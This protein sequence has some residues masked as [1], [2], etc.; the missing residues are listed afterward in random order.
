MIKEYQI[1][2]GQHQHEV[3]SSTAKLQEWPSVSCYHQKQHLLKLEAYKTMSSN[4][5]AK[6]ART[7]SEDKNFNYKYSAVFFNTYPCIFGRILGPEECWKIQRFFQI[8]RVLF[9][10][11]GLHQNAPL[12][13]ETFW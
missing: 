13:L 8:Y 1:L 12:V 3:F 2:T 5:S 10:I 11:F 9:N 4:F 6:Q 7:P